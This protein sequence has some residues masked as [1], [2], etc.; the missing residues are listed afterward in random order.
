MRSRFSGIKASALRAAIAAVLFC[1]V[2]LTVGLSAAP[3]LHH[4]LHKSD[5]GNHECAATQLSSSGWE[6]SAC[7][8]V[9]T[10]P[11]PAP[12]SPS[13]VR[14]GL[15]VIAQVPSSILEHAPPARS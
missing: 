1:G 5:G 13:L 15:R 10:V 3:Q 4:W 8:P 11:Q 9:L 6:H 14:P 7:D 12:V 2:A